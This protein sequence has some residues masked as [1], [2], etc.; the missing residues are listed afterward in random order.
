MS[1]V[2]LERRIAAHPTGLALLLAGPDA[3]PLWP[4]AA[5]EPAPVEEG[6]ADAAHDAGGV[7]LRVAIPD[8]RPAGEIPVRVTARRP[9]E[10]DA[11]GGYVV[12]FT[13]ASAGR[14][15]NGVVTLAYAPGRADERTDGVGDRHARPYE[16]PTSSVAAG[17]RP[18]PGTRGA[19]PY[20]T[21]AVLELT[22]PEGDGG[23]VPPAAMRAMGEGFLARLARAG[24][25]RA[26]AA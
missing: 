16:H 8:G 4:G 13:A 2:R 24:E 20:P 26:Q 14:A 15:V 11:E 1:T 19:P 18:D 7:R 22:L 25:E 23:T 21:R 9:R 3:Y 12:D 5:V 6:D 17:G 10:A